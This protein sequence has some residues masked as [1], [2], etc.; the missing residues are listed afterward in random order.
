MQRIALVAAAIAVL[1]VASWALL[2]DKLA[3]WSPASMAAKLPG[4][5]AGSGGSAEGPAPVEVVDARRADTTSDIQTVGSLMSDE[6]VALAPEIAG[7]VLEIA[8]EEGQAVRRDQIIVRLD[9]ALATA[10]LAQARARL[11]LATANNVRATRLSR[12]GTAAKRTGEEAQAIYEEVAASMEFAQLRVDRHVLRAPF[13]GIAGM[14]STSVGA[15]VSAGTKIVNI[16]KIDQL[17]VDFRIPEI[18]L[19]A[20]KAGQGVLVE[21]DALPGQTFEGTIYAIDPAIDINGR[22]LSVRARLPNKDNL[23][24]PGLFAR[25]TIRG[26][27]ERQVVLVPEGAVVPRAGQTLVFKVENGTAVAV[28]VLLGERRNGEVEITRGLEG[29]E[30]VVV[31]GQHRLRDGVQVEIVSPTGQSENDLPSTP[32]AAAKRS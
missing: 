31:A 25:I 16:E 14:R 30:S 17:K 7:R 11:K 22:S 21:V 20:V 12:S 3:F 32:P 10:E 18:H 29:P 8:F 5:Q 15:F 24:R 28:P 2:S 4:G 19:A 1:T 27:V 13:D 9:D 23:L 26:L 6:S